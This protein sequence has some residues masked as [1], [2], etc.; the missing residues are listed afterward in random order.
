ML[1][2]VMAVIVYCTYLNVY[3]FCI[4]GYFQVLYVK[5]YAVLLWLS[6]KANLRAHMFFLY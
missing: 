6:V 2:D 5:T 4:F 1:H 3:D